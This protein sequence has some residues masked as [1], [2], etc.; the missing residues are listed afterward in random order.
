VALHIATLKEFLPHGHQEEIGGVK[1][2][3]FPLILVIPTE[4]H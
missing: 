3:I 1:D 4:N 2:V